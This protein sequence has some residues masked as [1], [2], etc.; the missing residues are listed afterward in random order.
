ME[1]GAT[2]GY[3]DKIIFRYENQKNIIR[4]HGQSFKTLRYYSIRFNKLRLCQKFRKARKAL[5]M[6]KTLCTFIRSSYEQSSDE[7]E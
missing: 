5:R 4:S 3:L 2:S 6:I 7:Y 1:S